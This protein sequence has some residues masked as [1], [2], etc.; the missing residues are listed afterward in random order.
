MELLIT[1]SRQLDQKYKK[2]LERWLDTQGWKIKAIWHGGARGGDQMADRYAME[3]GITTVIMEP[4]YERYGSQRA[5]LIRNCDLVANTTHTVALHD[6]Q[7][8]S[9]TAYTT[10]RSCKAG[11]PTWVLNVK[12]G[13]ATRLK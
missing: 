13:E 12:T 9:G 7:M 1:G 5:P 4:D 3:R 10:R 11:H 6:G 8:T 2:T